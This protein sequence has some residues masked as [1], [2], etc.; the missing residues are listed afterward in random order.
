MG[1]FLALRLSE[2][3]IKTGMWQNTLSRS[4]ASLPWLSKGDQLERS[5]HPL[6]QRPPSKIMAVPSL[7]WS[8]IH[9]VERQSLQMF[10]FAFL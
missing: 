3:V 6:R 7:D 5:G 9:L 2:K 1:P 10:S 4:R 8:P